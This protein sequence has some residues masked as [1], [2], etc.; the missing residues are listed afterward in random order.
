[1]Q[2][3]HIKTGA[4]RTPELCIAWLLKFSCL[5][6]IRGQA[7]NSSINLMYLMLIYYWPKN[8]KM[9][10]VLPNQSTSTIQY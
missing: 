4:C 8:G 6:G 9:E 1:M 10:D 7:G 5:R 3:A 2:S